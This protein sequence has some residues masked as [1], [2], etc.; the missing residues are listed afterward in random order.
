MPSDSAPPPSL[1]PDAVPV[2]PFPALAGSRSFVSGHPDEGRLRVAYYRLPDSPTLYG[3]VWFGP[4]TQGPPGHAHGGSMA[5]VLDEAAGGA[6]WLAG[7]QILIARLT[8][9]FRQ[10]MPLGTDARLEAWVEGV[11]GRKVTTRARLLD[12]DGRPYAEAEALCVLL[13]ADRLEAMVERAGRSG[14][15]QPRGAGDGAS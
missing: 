14:P 8:T 1:P 10:V 7:H 13:P 11:D 3:R 5:A 2:D 4:E 9:D 15:P 6:A 12:A